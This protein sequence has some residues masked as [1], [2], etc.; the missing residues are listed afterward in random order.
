MI[1]Q[2]KPLTLQPNFPSYDLPPV[3]RTGTRVI[4]LRHGRSTL[5][6]EGRYQGS[7]D[8]GYLTPEGIA[9]SKMVGR[10]LAH[11]PIDAVYASP[12]QRARQTVA[13]LMPQLKVP[14]RRDVITTPLLKEIHLPAWEGRRYA[15][16][17]SRDADLYR[18]WQ[19]HPEQLQMIA[20]TNTDDAV[21]F[22][23]VR[24]VYQRA[25]QFWEMTLP[26]HRGQTILV[27]GHGSSNQALINTALGLPPQQHHT[28]QQTHSGLTVLDF[29]TPVDRAAKLHFLNMTVGDRLPKLK[30]GKQGLRL[31]L[32]PCHPSVPKHHE[33]TAFLKGETIDAAI[34]EETAD[35]SHS[36]GTIQA[37]NA[38]LQH[39]PLT[40]V[41][42]VQQMQL[43]QQWPAAI[44]R[45][46]ITYDHNH[47]T[48][49]LVVAHSDSLQAGFQS[50]MGLPA[51]A[52]I[53][54]LRANSLS[55]IHY[56][57]TQPQPILQGLN[58][59]P[60]HL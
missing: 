51:T 25:Q 12:L 23:P 10:Y 27:V 42:S 37:A 9:A 1:A 21:P 35:P 7:A 57:K 40:V 2:L 60:L 50:L 29:S 45:S 58:L 54:Q 33:I 18:C 14:Y 28:L 59:V 8:T 47:L 32:F 17:R 3:P 56:A 48:T 34:V 15:D 22:Y 24:D 13:A 44:R 46:L 38:A 41:L 5:N 31:L 11:C 43:T 6:D 36:R 16:V 4:F 55:V 52:A 19:A 26:Q 49:L 30:A 53:P 39:H 20:S